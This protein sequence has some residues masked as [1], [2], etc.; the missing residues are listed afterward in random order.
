MFELPEDRLAEAA[1]VLTRSF[2]TNPN[3]VN[4]FPD[5]R[6]CAPAHWRTCHGRAC[7]TPSPRRARLRG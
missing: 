7:A 5:A 6:R 1:G 2:L 3:F 4:L